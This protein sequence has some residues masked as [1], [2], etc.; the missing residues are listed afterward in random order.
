M[1]CISENF[2][3]FSFS[4]H[5]MNNYFMYFPGC[6]VCFEI[7]QH[8]NQRWLM[9][10]GY[11]CYSYTSADVHFERK[12]FSLEGHLSNEGMKS[13]SLFIKAA[14]PQCTKMYYCTAQGSLT[15]NTSSLGSKLSHVAYLYSASIKSPPISS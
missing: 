4:E 14:G 13:S 12:H 9:H 15:A 5:I 6:C 1:C 3:P 11:L 7:H 2:N 10:V 8:K